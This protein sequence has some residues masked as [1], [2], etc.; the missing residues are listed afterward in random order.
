MTV[1]AITFMVLSMVIVWGGLVLAILRLRKDGGYE[2][3]APHDL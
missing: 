1:T 3:E 2:D